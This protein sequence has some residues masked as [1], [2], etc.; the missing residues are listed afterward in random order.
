M[1]GLMSVVYGTLFLLNSIVI[2]DEKRFLSRVGL[3][4][5][6]EARNALGPTRKKMV[7]LIR[8]VRTVMKI[9]LVVLN[10]VFIAYEAFFG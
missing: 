9:P 10:I 1:F 4:L 3:P 2:L 7:D 6:P 8:A 5:S